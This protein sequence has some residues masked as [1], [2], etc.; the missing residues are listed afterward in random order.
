MVHLLIYLQFYLHLLWQSYIL[1][2]TASLTKSSTSSDCFLDRVS[3]L[4]GDDIEEPWLSASL[5]RVFVR[6]TVVTE[7]PQASAVL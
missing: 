3:L 5:N 2:R 4:R 7:T 6:Y 1:R